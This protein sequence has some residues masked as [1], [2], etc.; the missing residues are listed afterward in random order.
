MIFHLVP[1]FGATAP[2]DHAGPDA[3][4]PGKKAEN[5][6]RS[7]VDHQRWD[8][9][10]IFKTALSDGLVD[11]NPAAALFTPAGKPEGEKR[12]I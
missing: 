4:I 1:P 7:V 8:L 10:G 12:V 5:L 9:N 11:S 2:D 6:S 3:S